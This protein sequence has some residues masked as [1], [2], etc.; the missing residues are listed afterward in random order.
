VRWVVVCPCPWR[1]S[2]AVTSKLHGK[3]DVGLVQ[4]AV[5]SSRQLAELHRRMDA[6]E[7]HLA[8]LQEATQSCCSVA[9][10]EALGQ[11]LQ[12]L[13]VRAPN[14]TCMPVPLSVT[15]SERTSSLPPQHALASWLYRPPSPQPFR[16]L[17]F[18][19]TLWRTGATRLRLS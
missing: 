15:P 13:K 9:R 17:A 4:D 16:P 5:S 10:V 1:A 12:D 8:D 2:G 11:S 6:L 19:W 18:E 7:Q 3:A 14:R